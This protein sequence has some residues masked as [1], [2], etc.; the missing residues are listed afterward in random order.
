MINLPKYLC[1]QRNLSFKSEFT[2]TDAGVNG[3]D[4]DHKSFEMFKEKVHNI[5]KF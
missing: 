3:L 2:A 1:C 4:E 5:E